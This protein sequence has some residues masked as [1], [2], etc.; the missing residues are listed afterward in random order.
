MFRVWGLGLEVFQHLIGGTKKRSSFQELGF[1]VQGL[2]G[3]G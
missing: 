3:L 2:E 1:I